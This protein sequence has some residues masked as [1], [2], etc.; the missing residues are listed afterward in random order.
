LLDKLNSSGIRGKTNLWFKPYLAHRKQFVEINQIVNE[1]SIQ[2]KYISSCR[3]MKHEYHMA[4]FLDFF[5][6]YYV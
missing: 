4:Q 3:E 6:F 2:N 5:C 1:N